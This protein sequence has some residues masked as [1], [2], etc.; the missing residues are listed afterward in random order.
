MASTQ[1]VSKLTGSFPNLPT[2]SVIRDFKDWVTETGQPDRWKWH[3]HSMPPKDHDYDELVKF[4]IPDKKRADVGLARCPICSPNNGKY[5]KGVLTWFPAEGT[6]R[7][8]GHECAEKHFG[9]LRYNRARSVRKH[10]QRVD[11]ARDFLFKHLPTIS[12]LRREV[13]TNVPI[14]VDIDRIRHIVRGTVTKDACLKLVKLGQRGPL[15]L[16]ENTEIDV[17]DSYG[18]ARTNTTSRVIGSVQVE[19][20]GFLSRQF[21]TAAQARNTVQ[22]LNLVRTVNEEEALI[23]VCDTLANDDHLFQADKLTRAAIAEFDKLQDAL[24]EAK[25]FLHPDNLAKLTEWSNDFRSGAPFLFEFRQEYPARFGVRKRG[26]S[27]AQTRYIP[28]SDRLR[29]S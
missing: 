15:L 1:K 20:L 5:Y 27:S 11:A 23:F 24:A 28:I 6:I 10:R 2:P 7:A 13:E 26:K 3:D 8:I 4:E 18:K 25:M 14:S 12:S 19:G 21:L 29:K 22:A 17:T 9:T 16:Q